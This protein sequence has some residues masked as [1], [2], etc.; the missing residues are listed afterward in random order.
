MEDM[1]EVAE[2]A[3]ESS[4]DFIKKYRQFVNLEFL[5]ITDEVSLATRKELREKS[6]V[7]KISLD[8]LAKKC[9][10]EQSKCNSPQ[11]KQT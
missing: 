7:I 2:A 11:P 8:A 10:D 4:T 3:A 5:G 1:K 9:E 6:D